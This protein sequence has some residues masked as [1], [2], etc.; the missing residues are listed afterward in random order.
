MKGKLKERLLV[1]NGFYKY[2]FDNDR[3]EDGKQRYDSVIADIETAI[4]G[5]EG[6]SVVVS[7][8]RYVRVLY[9]FI[10]LFVC[11]QFVY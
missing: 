7:G 5:E 8:H 2:L 4:N 3:M 10:C 1:H 11:W 9:L 6:Y